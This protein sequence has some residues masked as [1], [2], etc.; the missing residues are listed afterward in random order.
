MP[1]PQ[2]GLRTG[3]VVEAAL[4]ADS[5]ERCMR[6]EHKGALVDLDDFQLSGS[7]SGL[8]SQ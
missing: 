8:L 1:P 7:M 4:D 3:S 6:S 2:A 5:F